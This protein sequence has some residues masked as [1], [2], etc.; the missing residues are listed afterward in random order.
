MYS[1]KDLAERFN[2]ARNTVYATLKAS[3]LPTDKQTYTEEEI[4]QFF[5]PARQLLSSGK[6]YDEVATYFATRSAGTAESVSSE[7]APSHG[8]GSSQALGQVLFEQTV[9]SVQTTAE[10]IVQQLLPYI[11]HLTAQ[12]LDQACH[13]GQIAQHFQSYERDRLQHPPQFVLPGQLSPSAMTALPFDP[14]A[15]DDWDEE[16]DVGQAEEMDSEVSAE[17]ES[18]LDEEGE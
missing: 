14:L 18:E 16:N 13:R 12:A 5:I 9:Q 4:Q 15:D 6:T 2:L 1:K 8:S 10:M 7:T 17:E 11:P 3:G